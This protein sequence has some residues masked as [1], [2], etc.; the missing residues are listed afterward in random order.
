MANYKVFVIKILYFLKQKTIQKGE[1]STTKWYKKLE[2]YIKRVLYRD[3]K[4]ELN[5]II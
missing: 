5:P 2:A 1:K 4:K 3:Y